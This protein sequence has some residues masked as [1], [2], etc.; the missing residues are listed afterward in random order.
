MA[1][2]LA[3]GETHRGAHFIVDWTDF[4]IHGR[5]AANNSAVSTGFGT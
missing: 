1:G 3:L 2:F 4:D 5:N